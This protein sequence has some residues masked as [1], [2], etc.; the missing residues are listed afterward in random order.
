M[1]ASSPPRPVAASGSFSTKLMLAWT[2]VLLG[3]LGLTAAAFIAANR[4]SQSEVSRARTELMRATGMVVDRLRAISQ[5]Q[6]SAQS[7]A[8]AGGALLDLQL[9]DLPAAEGGIWSSEGGF[10]AYVFPTYDGSLPKTQQP[11]AELPRIEALVRRALDSGGD[12]ADI[13]SVAGERE[14][15]VRVAQALPAAASPN[16]AIVVWTMKR[17]PVGAARTLSRGALA[18][19]GLSLLIVAAGLWLAF[20]LMQWRRAL[21]QLRSALS[22]RP[23]ENIPQVSAKAAVELDDIAHAINA[24]S[25]D[26]RR[27]RADASSLA[28]RL[29]GAER[30]AAV[31]RVAAALAHEIRNPIATIRLRA[32]NALAAPA[33]GPSPALTRI[34]EEVDRLERLVRSL[35]ELGREISLRVEPVRVEQW[36]NDVLTTCAHSAATKEIRLECRV[37]VD[38]WPFDSAHLGRATAGLLANAIEFSPRGGTVSLLLSSQG[39]QLFVCVADEGPGVPAELAERIFEPFFTT[40]AG[41]NG[42]GLALVREV[43]EAHGGTVELQRQA[44]GT[45]FEMRIPWLASS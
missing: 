40:R 33:G 31:G 19:A 32:E 41:G 21:A 45:R 14:T 20:N 42:L 7:I 6:S 13:E 24:L 43:A 25:I 9:S 1:L 27:A 34:I 16:G 26:L 10:L 35:L 17:V 23:P 8:A 36:A 39:E 4:S 30:L 18:A 2:V 5:T 28:S 37:S 3:A 11:A 29:R 44:S 22:V 38:T 15:L 12:R